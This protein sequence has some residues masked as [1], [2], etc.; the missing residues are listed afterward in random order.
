LRHAQ[1]F[2][3]LLEDYRDEEGDLSLAS[4][5]DAA[6]SFC[7]PPGSRGLLPWRPSR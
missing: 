3:E 5:T 2:E 6:I 7:R 1:R 4:C